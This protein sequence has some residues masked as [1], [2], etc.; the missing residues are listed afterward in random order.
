MGGS[1]GA[2]AGIK[3]DFCTAAAAGATASSSVVVQGGIFGVVVFQIAW[4]TTNVLYC[5]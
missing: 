1:V 4:N 5:S 3:V 2:V